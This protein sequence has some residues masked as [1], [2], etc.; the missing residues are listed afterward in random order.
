MKTIIII[1][2]SI[3]LLAAVG[4]GA[5]LYGTK[6]IKISLPLSI[7]PSSTST[8]A[9]P[10][11]TNTLGPLFTGT[12]AKLNQ[13]LNIFK[14][15]ADDVANGMDKDFA[16]YQAGTFTRGDLKGYTRIIAVRPSGGPGQPLTYVLATKDYQ[17]YYLDDPDGNTS[18]YA[19]TDWNNPYN[20]VD[21]SVII[22]AA[23]FDTEQPAEIDLSSNFALYAEQIST[24]LDISSFK[25]LNSPVSNLTFYYQPYTYVGGDVSGLSQHDKDMQALR[26]HYFL[27]MTEIVAVDSSGLP[28]L[29]TMTTPE[30]AKVY[31]QKLAIYQIAYQKYQAQLAVYNQTHT[32]TY[33]PSPEYVTLPSMGF[34]SAN[35]N[36][37]TGLQFYTTYEVA[38]PGACAFTLNSRILNVS[39]ADLE[40]IGT[41]SNL[42][43]Y[44]L[45]DSKSSLYDLAFNTKMDPYS[46]GGFANFAEVNKG[47]KQPTLKDYVSKN[48]LLFVKDYWQRW[49]ALGEYDLKLPGGCGKPV[50]Y[51][52]PQKTTEISVKFNAPVQFTTDIPTYG[53]FWKIIAHQDGSLTNLRPE[54]TDCQTLN[55]ASFGSEYAKAACLKNS[56][57][58]LYWSGNILSENYPQIS[59]GWVVAQSELK[60]FFENKLTEVGLNSQERSDFV[61]YWLPEMMIKNS[62]YYRVSF[63]Q[64][65]E[66]NAMF[67]MTVAPAP[68]TIFR[69]FLD[70]TPLTEKPQ[71]LPIP[72]VLNRLVRNGFTLVEWGG[73]R[74]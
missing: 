52:Y 46:I 34:E 69:L 74:K 62:P 50:I 12:F 58:Y 8:T 3:S 65:Q 27:E 10:T 54:L 57:P 70:Y 1:L 6:N 14:V 60:S 71:I 4:V 22:S 56:Y 18:K 31:K 63:F 43:L 24:D 72:Q 29:Y 59:G 67:P 68:N 66:L 37:S 26:Q 20:F 73:L 7:L 51:L 49:V 36:G 9:V 38:I 16:F 39:D 13:K 44:R 64:T 41:V 35:I 21:R 48:P 40:Q 15:T 2:L 11:A 5:Y 53:D 23:T 33:P 42:P 47:I 32:G 25:T 45:K 17:K 28:M 30:N 19:E 61:S 55:T